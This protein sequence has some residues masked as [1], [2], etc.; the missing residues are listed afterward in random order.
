MERIIHKQKHLKV[1]S[2]FSG[3]GGLD[4]GFESAGFEVIWAN[5]FDKFA[6]QTYKANINHN[7]IQG[8][9]RILK[10]SIP[11]HD[12]LIGG[13]PCQPF[14]TLGKMQGFDDSKNRGTLF[15]EIMD[16]VSKHKTKVIVLENVINLV[17]H[18][19]HRTFQRILTEL[20][21]AGYYTNWKI[22]NTCDFGV[23]QSRR[24]VF[25]VAFRKDIFPQI[26]LEY[27]KPFPLSVTTQDLMDK[28]VPIRHF[29]T[30]RV[31]HTI[32][33]YTEK[34][35]NKYPTIDQPVSKALCASM[36]KWHRASQDN[37]LTDEINFVRNGAPSDRI[38]VRR[39][40]PN[41]CRK[42][43]GFPNDW[44]Q[45]VS[46]AQAYKQF[47]NAVTVDVAYYVAER[48]KKHIDQYMRK[49]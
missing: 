15:F 16:I 12:I 25:I 1:V 36:N 20:D 42:L 11:E 32:L 22:L 35:A 9:I 14:S 17:Y 40:T 43:Q 41:E 10:D 8:D 13:F 26:E 24:R 44:N 18:D 5:D 31:S 3:I 34:L 47:G 30:K 33:D 6:V 29:L 21:Q 37:Y 38:N 28:D 7:I 49:S 2:L 19:Q 39:L 46:D 23:P 48:I 27:P 45:V 4:L